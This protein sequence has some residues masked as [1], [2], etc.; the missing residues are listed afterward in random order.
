MQVSVVRAEL[1]E[2]YAEAF[3]PV[4]IAPGYDPEYEL[5]I[6]QV[7]NANDNLL[8][9]AELQRLRY[10]MENFYIGKFFI[11]IPTIAH[12]LLIIIVFC[13]C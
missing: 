2:R 9:R 4:H 11:I 5:G 1:Q 8:F 13:R 12:Y 10:L 3:I 6:I 7:R